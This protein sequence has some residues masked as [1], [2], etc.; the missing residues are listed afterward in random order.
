[1]NLKL[2]DAARNF[3]VEPKKI[4]FSHS[5]GISNDISMNTDREK[6]DDLQEFIGSLTLRRINPILFTR[7]HSFVQRNRLD[8]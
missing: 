4:L 6:S 7:P 8:D 2:L 1:M 3:I 5:N